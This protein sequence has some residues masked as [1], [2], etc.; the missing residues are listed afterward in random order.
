V[1]ALDRLRGL[2]QLSAEEGLAIVRAAAT[3]YTPAKHKWMDTSE[4]LLFLASKTPRQE[5]LA[6]VRESFAAYNDQTK[7]AAFILVGKVE[8]REAAETL[9]EF[10]GQ[11]SP[12]EPVHAALFGPVEKKP[13]HADIF[14]PRIMRFATN[15]N[16]AGSIYKLCLEFCNAGALDPAT[17]SQ[18]AGQV[19]ARYGLFHDQLAPLQR[20]G[21]RAFIWEDRYQS[22][23]YE[24]GMLLDLMGYL[25][26][27]EVE[28]TLRRALVYSDMR[29]RVFATLSLLRLG[30][31]VDSQRMEEV[32]ADN[33]AR[34]L[35]YGGL[36]KLGREE[37]FP[38]AYRNQDAFAESKM[39]NWLTFPTELARVPDEIQLMK[40]FRVDTD[41]GPATY[42]LFRFQSS[43]SSWAK[44]GWMTGASGPF[45]E[46]EQP[47]VRDMN[48]TFSGF[49][50][51]ESKT[52]AQ[53]I[54]AIMSWL[55][56]AARNR[57][58][59]TT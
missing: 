5:Y 19:I 31:N 49:E 38:E 33:E 48:G 3:R 50:P 8:S 43:H 11:Y 13:R 55:Q 51:W 37:M 22:L 16:L 58:Q 2:G 4:Q 57:E 10:L 34:N 12:R 42:Y 59:Q 46:K 44:K 36:K 32:A 52:P 28:P 14:F 21:S 1:T 39:V 20:P 53:H 27:A 24:A 41:D 23:R 15:P 6:L 47:T 29:L 56:A 35:L 25:P 26:A 17:I 7:V 18:Y 40:K 9:M 30:T 54:E 45:L